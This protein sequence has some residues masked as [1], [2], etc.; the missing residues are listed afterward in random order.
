MPKGGTDSH[1][2]RLGPQ[3]VR[4]GGAE[5]QGSDGARTAVPA[6][7]AVAPTGRLAALLAVRWPFEPPMARYFTVGFKIPVGGAAVPILMR[8][9][10]ASL[11]ESMWQAEPPV[12]RPP[13]HLHR[14]SAAGLAALAATGTAERATTWPVPFKVASSRG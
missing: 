7:T 9:C 13:R 8:L 11:L 14:L 5:S 12:G 3:A 10:D 6:V 4:I 2:E 1:L